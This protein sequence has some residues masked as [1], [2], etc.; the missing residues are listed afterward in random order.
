MKL[1][2][3]GHGTD[4]QERIIKELGEENYLDDERFAIAYA[5]GKSRLKKW[6]PMKIRAGLRLKRVPN[7]LV[8]LALNKLVKEDLKE[9]MMGLLEQHWPRIKGKDL[10]ERKSKAVKFLMGKG[11]AYGAAMKALETWSQ[12]R[13]E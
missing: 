1:G 6:G 10:W 11:Y 12:E 5:E 3:M 7:D 8:D 2:R 9:T 13:D 4:I